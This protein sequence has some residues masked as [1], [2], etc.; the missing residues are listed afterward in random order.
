[1]IIPIANVFNNRKKTLVMIPLQWVLTDCNDSIIFYA[2]RQNNLYK[3]DLTDLTNQNVT[4][5]VSINDDQW[6]HKKLSHASLR[7]ISKLKKA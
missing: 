3:I 6:W 7:F 5:L 2:K 1:M 4:C